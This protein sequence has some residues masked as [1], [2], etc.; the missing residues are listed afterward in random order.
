MKTQTSIKTEK[1][2]LVSQKVKDVLPQILIDYLWSLANSV[3]DTESTLQVFKLSWN[4]L[5]GRDVQ[6]ITHLAYDIGVKSTRRVFGI[7]PVNEEIHIYHN[8][9]KEEYQMIIASLA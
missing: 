3:S 9:E 5:S 1:V 4:M 2:Q 7:R 8:H 6:D